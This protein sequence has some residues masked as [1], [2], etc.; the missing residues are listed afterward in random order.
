MCGCDSLSLSTK[1]STSDR[2]YVSSVWAVVAYN[3]RVV[4]LTG[5]V[6]ENMAFLHGR[7]RG[8]YSCSVFYLTGY[9]RR[10]VAYQLSM[11]PGSYTK[12]QYVLDGWHIYVYIRMKVV[13]NFRSEIN[14][15]THLV[16]SIN[17]FRWLMVK[18]CIGLYVI[19][20]ILNN[21]H[22]RVLSNTGTHDLD[23]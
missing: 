5:Y 22:L 8:F 14:T 19:E 15:E 20:L 10:H 4:H 18:D 2:A 6:M 21:P 13:I 3:C 11:E 23:W 7:E 12:Y 16:V 17:H 1:Y 9:V